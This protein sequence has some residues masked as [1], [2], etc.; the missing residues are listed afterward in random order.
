MHGK[1]RQQGDGSTI[2][3]LKNLLMDLQKLLIY[4]SRGTKLDLVTEKLFSRLQPSQ[5][6]K[7][8]AESL[9]SAIAEEKMVN[10]ACFLKV[11]NLVHFLARQGLPLR[12]D[13]EADWNFNQLLLDVTIAFQ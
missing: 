4:L 6:D 9:T 8:V 11:L 10:R 1:D 7:N 5:L 2:S 12:G 13:N 3:D